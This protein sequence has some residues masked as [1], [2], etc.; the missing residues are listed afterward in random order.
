MNK[1]YK[2]Q[3]L[4]I[5]NYDTSGK[6]D[7]YAQTFNT[8]HCQ[9]VVV[10]MWIKLCTRLPVG[11]KSTESFRDFKNKLRTPFIQCKSLL[12]MLIVKSGSK[13]IRLLFGWNDINKVI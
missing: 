1:I 2:T 8:S 4:N 3:N 5:H 6:E 10:N 7:L 12:L 13:N 11:I 9:K